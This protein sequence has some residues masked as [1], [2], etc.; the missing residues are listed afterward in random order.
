MGGENARSDTRGGLVAVAVDGACIVADP[1][2]DNSRRVW[3]P[4]VAEWTGDVVVRGLAPG[5][6]AIS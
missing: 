1:L 3:E 5:A 2:S 4:A 6:S